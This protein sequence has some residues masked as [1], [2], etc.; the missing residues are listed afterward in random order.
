MPDDI[1]M[2]E[3]GRPVDCSTQIWK[4]NTPGAPIVL[5]WDLLDGLPE[6]VRD[7]ARTYARH[8]IPRW[9]PPTLG[10]LFYMYRLLAECAFGDGFDGTI[11]MRAFEELRLDD[12]AGSSEL[13]RYRGWYEW[14][15]ILGLRGFDR[16]VAR[17]LKKVRIG[18]NPHRRPA[19]KKDP[20]LG[21][22]T[23]KERQELLNKTLNASDEELPLRERVAILLGMGLAPNA[24]PLS[25]LQVQDYSTERSGATTYHLLMV[26]RHKKGFAKERAD[27]RPRQIEPKWAEYLERLIAHNRTKA[28]TLYR[29]S[30]GAPKPAHVSVPIFMGSRIRTDSRAPRAKLS[31]VSARARTRARQGGMA[32]DPSATSLWAIERYS[33]TASGGTCILDGLLA[34]LR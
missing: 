15:A 7:A 27:F 11:G 24:G 4:L 2:D 16:A 31:L 28:D 10:G 3:A 5:D 13:T 29:S 33:N 19:R 30:T 22:L 1:V 32:D 21:P 14:A 6:P 18:A 17:Q 8:Q 12:R 20:D 26:P 34:G 25:L 9:G 23:D